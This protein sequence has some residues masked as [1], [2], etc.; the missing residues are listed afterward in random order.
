MKIRPTHHTNAP[1]RQAKNPRRRLW[2]AGLFSVILFLSSGCGTASIV[3]GTS[4]PSAE[5]VIAPAPLVKDTSLPATQTAPPPAT[6]IKDPAMPAIETAPSPAVGQAAVSSVEAGLLA[7]SSDNEERRP[8]ASMA[9]VITALAIMEKQRFEPGQAGQTYTITE[10]DIE[11]MQTNIAE[12][13]STLPLLIGMKLTQYQAIQ[14]L[15]TDGVIGI[16][17]GTTDEAG[18]CLLYAAC[19]AAAD[20]QKV[21]I[22]GVIMGDTDAPSLFSDSLKL[23]ASARQGLGLGE[24]H[25]ASTV[26]EPAP[27]RRPRA[28]RP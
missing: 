23:L 4:I 22:V 6:R 19:Y 15:G 21:T 13:G 26:V 12:D 16:K 25:P 1:D 3:K 11:S 20:G 14:L 7:R 27:S 24:A 28:A 18:H 10:Q 8:T 17:T 2:S 5:M 9:K